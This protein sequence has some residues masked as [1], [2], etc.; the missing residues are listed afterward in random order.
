[1]RIIEVKECGLQCPYY[2]TMY[3][4]K[5]GICEHPE[6]RRHDCGYVFID[7]LEGYEEGEK[8]PQL[9]KLKEVKQ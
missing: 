4:S 3:M 6:L 9:C 7:T 1:M 2:K 8:F 5:R